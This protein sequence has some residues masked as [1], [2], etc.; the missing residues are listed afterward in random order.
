MGYKI[1]E[2]LAYYYFL[3]GFILR[4]DKEACK[5]FWLQLPNVL[6]IDVWRCIACIVIHDM[7][8]N[9]GCIDKKPNKFENSVAFIQPVVRCAVPTVSYDM[10]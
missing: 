3:P 1:N 5:L 2:N 7:K 4:L 10:Q 9:S 6:L 8:V